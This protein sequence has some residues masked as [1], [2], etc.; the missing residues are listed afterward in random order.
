MHSSHHISPR[1]DHWRRDGC[2][3]CDEATPQCNCAAEEKCILTSRTCNQCP[4]INC[5]K[6]ASSKSK[7][8]NPGAI[9]GPVVAVL[10]IASLGLFWW[11]RRKKR[12][13][14]ARLEAL[15]ARARKAESAGFQLS[16]PPSPQPGSAH[17]RSSLPQRPPSAARSRSPLPPAPVNAEYYDDHGATI[18]VY[19]GSRGT[20]HVDKND[21]NDP[22]SDR[23]SISTMGSGGTA[24]IIPIQYIPPSRSDEA[25]S[26]KSAPDGPSNQ[27]AAAKALDAARQNLFH[28]RRPAR[29][30]DLDLR[31][32]PPT[33]N[34]NG[35]NLGTPSA[36]SFLSDQRSPS[37]SGSTSQYRDSF[38]SGNS[39]APSYWS[40]QS[41]VHLD[42]PKIVT[43]KQVQIGR[44]QQAE[45]VQFG[46]PHSIE[47]LSPTINGQLS[48]VKDENALQQQ[49]QQKVL[50][51]TAGSFNSSQATTRTLTP[52]SNRY[53]EEDL[54]EG[55][56][57]AEPSSAGSQDLRFS[58]GS[59][60]YDRNSVST[61]GTGRYLASA[62]STGH[63]NTSSS[64]LP[65]P[66]PT[67]GQR[68]SSGSSKSFADSVL[69]S[70]PMI[71]P[72]SSSALPTTHSGLPQS[73]STNTLEHMSF[74]RPSTAYN[75][76][77][78]SLVTPTG[79]PAGKKQRP[80]TQASVADSFLGSFPFVQP[81]TEDLADLPTPNVPTN[82]SNRGVSTSSEG[83]GGFE[84]R[85][86]EDAPPVPMGT[87]R[88]G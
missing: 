85:L 4:T 33:T 8:V 42:A 56:R 60:A 82:A 41:D 9:A 49:Q 22:F 38:L 37:G 14:L 43:S 54:E 17:S 55:L 59:L 81:N 19:D 84:F 71:P 83:L 39:A 46:K 36:Y 50:S 78:K 52:I 26:K 75:P 77:S 31:L 53:N 34:G 32:N 62:I 29:A 69:G 45:V 86:A 30:P 51:P 20:I 28:P 70:F 64:Q 79:T 58:M 67:G 63:P 6:S 88:R 15:A 18:R 27:S 7:G 65:L 16:Q 48:P 24:N 68:N 21:S 72:N 44:L 5:I 2:V 12:R 13:D 74:S 1:L 73:T 66:P 25:L 10:V 80:E 87:P 47:R 57:S 76:N 40:G 23:Q 3:S 35:T 11:L 61:M